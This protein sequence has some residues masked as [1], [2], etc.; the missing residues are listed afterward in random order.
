MKVIKTFEEHTN[1]GLRDEN[2][3]STLTLY[4]GTSEY[5]AKI[6]LE[7]GWAPRFSKSM[8]ANG[9]QSKYL[10]LTSTPINAQWYAN[11]MGENTILKVENIPLQYLIVDPEDGEGYTMEETLE[12]IKSGRLAVC[13]ALTK[14]LSSEHFSI[15]T[16]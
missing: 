1:E 13:F 11:E 15:Y 4:H 3:V 16:L 6:L 7:N 12:R 9:G 14:P 8:T 5:A 10:Y 2:T